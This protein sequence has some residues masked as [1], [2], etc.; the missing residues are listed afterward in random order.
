MHLSASSAH[1]TRV[2]ASEQ[3][4]PLPFSQPLGRAAHTHA[5]VGADRH[6]DEWLGAWATVFV[7]QLDNLTGIGEVR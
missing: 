2:V 5:A 7:G 4:V 3:N 1:S 6:D